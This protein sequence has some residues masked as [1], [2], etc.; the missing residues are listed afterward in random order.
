MNEQKTW[1]R[2]LAA[3]YA[4]GKWC[5]VPFDFLAEFGEA[6]GVFLAY[7]ANTYALRIAKGK[8]YHKKY[9]IRLSDRTI[10]KHLRFLSDQAIKKRL[11]ELVREGIVKIQRRGL[12]SRR[13]VYLNIEALFERL[14]VEPAHRTNSYG[15]AS[16]NSYSQRNVRCIR[17][18]HRSITKNIH[19][20][21][22][23]NVEWEALAKQLH[24]AISGV[25]LVP[26]NTSTRKWG[27]DM[28]RLHTTDGFKMEQIEEIL[29]WYCKALKLGDPYLP[30]AHCGSTFREKFSRVEAAMRRYQMR[31]GIPMK[32]MKMKSSIEE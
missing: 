20:E 19:C 8:D 23:K 17:S 5:Q 3:C 22:C 13:W 7:L 6:T 4:Y 24:K 12:P 29:S 10:R 31:N 32:K 18:I 11:A 26:Q 27:D 21:L 15:V 2:A 25:R 9:W 30:V 14:D 16:T 1:V 28:R